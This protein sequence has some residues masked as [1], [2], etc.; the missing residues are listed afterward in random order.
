[1]GMS[2]RRLL[3]EFGSDE[4]SEWMGYYSIEPFGEERADLRMSFL[5]TLM[6]NVHRRSGVPAFRLDDFLIGHGRKAERA[7]ETP[8]DKLARQKALFAGINEH[9]RTQAKQ[10]ELIGHGG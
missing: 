6:H 5:T 2:V 7:A 10:G 8:Q 3:S 4:L 9:L 1:M